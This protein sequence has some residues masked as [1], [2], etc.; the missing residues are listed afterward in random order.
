MSQGE[1]SEQ[2]LCHGAEDALSSSFRK[3]PPG[4]D[5]VPNAE[6]WEERTI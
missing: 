6:E 5:Y 3:A 4:W 1:A 2:R